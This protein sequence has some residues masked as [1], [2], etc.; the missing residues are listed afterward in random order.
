MGKIGIIGDI[1][2]NLIALQAVLAKL[3]E[4]GCG[5][6]VCTGDVVGYGPRPA[7]C[8]ALV[9]ERGIPTVLGNHDHYTT[10]LMDPRLESLRDDVK[11]TIKWTQ[12]VLSMSDLKWLAQL[13]ERQDLEHFSI[14]HGSFGPKRWAYLKSERSLSVN[15]EH[16]DVPLAF[17]GHT[18]VPIFAYE[19]EGST[20]FLTYLRKT[21]AVTKDKVIIN[22][23]AVGQPR[24]HDPRAACG[25]FDVE[26]RTIRPV[27]VPYDIEKTQADMRDQ[28]VPEAFIE[29]LTEGR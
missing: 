14:V 26:E 20:P 4:E 16:Q 24:D 29:R 21:T 2:S 5:G 25:I 23:G 10:L 15:F 17:C 28:G 6:I 3:D 13:P 8:I 1:H 9:R 18:H 22:V 12:S 7:E 11:N 19:R 27:R